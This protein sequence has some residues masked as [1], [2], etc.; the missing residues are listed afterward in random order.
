MSDKHDVRKT[1]MTCRSIGSVNMGLA[2]ANR[3]TLTLGLVVDYNNEPMF[4]Q[5]QHLSI[6]P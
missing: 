3:T 2:T 5:H 1:V 6:V 4:S